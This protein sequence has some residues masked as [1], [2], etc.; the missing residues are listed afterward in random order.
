MTL[1]QEKHKILKFDKMEP[2]FSDKSIIKTVDDW[3]YVTQ[4]ID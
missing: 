4:L 3:F 2:V 1:N